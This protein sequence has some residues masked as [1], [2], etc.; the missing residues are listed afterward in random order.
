VSKSFLKQTA[1]FCQNAD[2]PQATNQ[3]FPK[4]KNLSRSEQRYVSRTAIRGAARNLVRE[5]PVTDVAAFQT[6]TIMD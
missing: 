3:N 4:K 6:L 1:S 5:G 2:Y